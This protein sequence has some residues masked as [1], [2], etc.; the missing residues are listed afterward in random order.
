MT[1]MGLDSLV[2]ARIQEFRTTVYGDSQSGLVAAAGVHR[3]RERGDVAALAHVENLV[4]SLAPNLVD[5]DDGV[6]RDVRALHVFELRLELLLGR[7]DEDGGTV[8]RK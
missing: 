2:E 4:G 6:E 5:A 7:I 8:L 3:D 1:I